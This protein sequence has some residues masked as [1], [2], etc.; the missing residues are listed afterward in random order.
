[1]DRLAYIALLAGG[2]PSKYPDSRLQ[3]VSIFGKN[4]KVSM[5]SRRLND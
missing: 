4:L 1:L 3:A 5:S 2:R